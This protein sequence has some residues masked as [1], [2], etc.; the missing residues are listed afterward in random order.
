MPWTKS[1]SSANPT[2]FYFFR[3]GAGKILVVQG[4]SGAS[5]L[6]STRHDFV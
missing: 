4:R 1:W 5:F 3:P 6:N 2:I